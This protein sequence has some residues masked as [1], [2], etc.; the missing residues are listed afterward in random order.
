MRIQRLS[1]DRF[2]HFNNRHYEF[3]PRSDRPD[4][5][6]IYGPNEAGKT[7]TMEAALRLFYGFPLRETYGFK[8]Q[9][10]NLQVSATLDIDG[11]LREFTRLPKRSGALVDANGTALPETALSAHLAGLT[12]EDYRQL[13]CLDDDTIER[14]GEEIAQ[15]KGDIGRLLFSAAA[16]VADLSAVLDGV[17]E[18]A[19]AIWKKR[20]SKTRIAELKR[21]LAEVEKTIRERDITA[22]AWRTLRK[23]LSDAQTAEQSARKVRS[24]LQSTSA[25]IA[26]QR[27]AIPMMGE[28][29]A[30]QTAIA[31]FAEYPARLD[32]D[33]ERLVQLRS[34]ETTARS[35][36]ERLEAEVTELTAARTLITVD[37][38]HVA[39][40][41]QLDAL[42][43]LRIRDRAAD[44]DMARRQDQQRAAEE[45]MARAA[46]DLGAPAGIAPQSLVL[47]PADIIRLE[48]TREA[49]RKAEDI[50]LTETDELA[51]LETRLSAA[52]EECDAFGSAGTLSPQVGEI[53]SR[54]DVDRLAPSYAAATQAL[55][56]A[57][58]TAAEHLRGLTIGPVRFDTLPS[59]PCSPLKAKDWAEAQADLLQKRS[60]AADLKAQH[61]TDM[62]ARIAQAEALTAHGNLVADAETDAL[63]DSRD[64]LWRAH[65]AAL[66]V[67]TATSFAIAMN[68]LDAAMKS[69]VARASDL[70]QLRQIEQAR[71]EAEVR[72]D[73]ATS[74][75]NELNA[76]LAA[77]EKAVNDAAS[78]V[79]LPTPL[80]PAEWL[81]WVNR[82]AGA[83]ESAG[84]LAALQEMH[85]PVLD[86]A[87]KLVETL[88][89]LVAL[90]TPDFE[91]LIAASRKIAETERETAAQGA[92]AQYAL[93]QAQKDRADRQAKHQTALQAKAKAEADWQGLVKELL[94]GAIAPQTLMASL[95]PLRN[96]REQEEQRA[97]ATRRV[98]TM[99]ADQ[100][101]FASEV[102]ALAARHGVT[103]QEPAATCFDALRDLSNT[104]R[105]GQ[106]K[107]AELSQRIEKA[108]V[109][110]GENERNLSQIAQEVAAIAVL[111]PGGAGVV[112]IDALR[113][114]TGGALQVIADRAALSKLERTILSELGAAEMAEAREALKD[115]TI[116]SLD[117]QA[118]AVKSDLTSAEDALT[119]A[120]EKRVTAEQG[121]ALVTGDAD[122]ASLTERKTTLELQ[123]EEAALEHLELSLGHRLASGAIRRYRDSH[124]SGMMTATERCFA[125]LTHGAYP[126]LTTLP[127]GAEEILLAVDGSG[128]SKRA[129]DMSKGTRFQLYLALRAAAHEQ[130]V[131]QGTCLPFFC[132][133]I[134]ETFDEERTSAACRV[135][136]DIGRK[137][138]AIYLTHHRHVVDIAMKTCDT[139]P[140]VHEI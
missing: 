68:A 124:R 5:H 51:A 84:R 99:Q 139:P 129:S 114:M 9:R 80:T 3:G 113:K 104:A 121:L 42:E 16:G 77:V 31:P 98:A 128:T 66:S 57:K 118:E 60:K 8:H 135:M 111:F 1:L 132:D 83:F 52:Q 21:D 34:E 70:G 45:A 33:P 119:S 105:D 40:S 89:P 76:D 18:Q 59:C 85:Q 78:Q 54:H 24:A 63:Q 94:G 29:S 82:H 122:I 131:G 50:A 71:A 106:E 41:E 4:F 10:S 96:L 12:E 134:F 110:I 53:L 32:F 101:R 88:G 138:Q 133:D 112:D 38:E 109:S 69:R 123:L 13:L 27:R 73:R 120:T 107:H 87:Q 43:D 75:L 48:K 44:M 102:A 81:D 46:H 17:R 74:Q 67:E 61:Q 126:K 23:S 116:A 86:R 79:G 2:G 127:D 14:G 100:H 64:R 28:I 19:D 125:S 140:M 62:A 39:L 36:M 58:Q 115:V 72:A 35:E 95:E 56:I 92:K 15:A 130:L 20:A 65:E 49:L 108:R 117:A 103:P 25:Q 6:I 136:E 22:N 11:Q 47:S 90:E 91:S 26:A 137:G 7:T 93:R 37:P 55:T 30:L 97:S